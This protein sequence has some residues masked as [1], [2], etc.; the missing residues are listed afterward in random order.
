MTTK[1]IQELNNLSTTRLHIGQ[2]LKISGDPDENLSS[3]DL[4]TYVVK[5][6]DSLFDI[7][8]GHQIP[9]NR[10]LRI[11]ALT[12]DSTIYPGQKLRIEQQ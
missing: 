9:L 5:R 6:G 3:N 8:Q 1:K 4:K 11:N 10:F 12:P 2:V 7:A